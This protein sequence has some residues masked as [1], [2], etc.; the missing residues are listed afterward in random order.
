MGANF[1]CLINVCRIILRFRAI[2][3]KASVSPS[4]VLHAALTRN[5]GLKIY[6]EANKL[7]YLCTGP[8]TKLLRLLVSLVSGR[9]VLHGHAAPLE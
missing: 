6:W 1:I 5:K 7:I 9:T 8:I 2:A 3:L 4:K